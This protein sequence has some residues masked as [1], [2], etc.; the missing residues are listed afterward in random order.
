MNRF[1]DKTVVVTGASRGLGRAIAVAFA[2]EGAY[3]YVA[4]RNRA[5]EAARTLELMAKAGGQ[6][7]LLP[8][9]VRDHDGVAEAFA[10]V[11][12]ERQT[13]HVLVNNAGVARDALFPLMSADDWQE[14]VDANLT[15]T[16]HCTS[17][18]VRLMLVRK[19]GAIINVASAAGIRAAAGQANYSASKGGVLALTRSLAA[20]LAPRGLRVNAVVPGLLGAGMALRLDHRIAAEQKARIP[21]GRAGT[22]EEVARVVLFLASDDASYVVGQCLPVDGG[23]T[24]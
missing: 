18:A 3:V 6:G 24:L 5:D 11:Q 19:S 17:A 20:E 23:L 14:V 1:T 4:F 15:G 8:F 12:R 16:F 9:D 7:A 22:A 10:R 2:D 13:L 21:L